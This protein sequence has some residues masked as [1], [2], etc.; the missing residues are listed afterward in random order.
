MKLAIT[1]S[2]GRIA[3]LF[4]TARNILVLRLEDG[5]ILDSEERRIEGG[6]GQGRVAALLRANVDSLICG[7]ITRELSGALESRGVR[8]QGFVSGSVHG[9]VQAF[10]DGTLHSDAYSMPGC[11]RRRRRCRAGR[12]GDER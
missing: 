6:G 7:A 10:Q 12:T 8:V 11:G 1:V 2:A 9:V 5:C 3:P 4:D